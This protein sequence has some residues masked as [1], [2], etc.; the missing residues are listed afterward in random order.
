MAVCVRFTLD[1]RFLLLP[2]V[3][4]TTLLHRANLYWLLG[5]DDVVQPATHQ[6]APHTGQA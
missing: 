4:H 2:N 5:D 3:D 1:D 6:P